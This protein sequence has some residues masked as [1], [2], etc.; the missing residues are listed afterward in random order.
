MKLSP[1]RPNALTSRNEG[2]ARLS[3]L[4]PYLEERLKEIQTGLYPRQHLWGID[5]LKTLK[6]VEVEHLC[7]N[8]IFLPSVLEK[9][10]NRAFFRNSPGAKAEISALRASKRSELIYSVCG[11]LSLLPLF[12]KAKLVSWVFRQPPGDAHGVFSPY[13]EEKL[14]AHA[15]FLCLTER[16]VEFFSPHAPSKFM[17]WCVDLKIFDGNPPKEKPKEPFFLAAGKTGRDFETLIEAA[18]QVKPKIR[19][20]GPKE[21]KPA[22]LPANV[23][24]LDCS[25]DPPDKAIDYPTLREWYAQCTA[26]CI[27]LSGDREDTCGYTNMLEGM[28]MAKPVIMT[29]SGCLHLDPESRGFGF[30]TSPNSYREWAEKINLLARNEDLAIKL[31]KNGRAIAE[32]EFSGK[33][34]D[35]DLSRFFE[36]L[37]S[38][39]K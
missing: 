30:L 32:E 28:A 33:R 20:I 10:L 34:F 37:L 5:G 15:A 18:R 11:P 16:C 13:R 26:V 25:N 14:K 31:G 36:K 9:L 21:H 4:H 38:T 6:N 22:N 8:S 3:V 1:S 19:I 12:G 17:P 35:A 23:S 2:K 39:I 24:W 29:R 7:S 27:P